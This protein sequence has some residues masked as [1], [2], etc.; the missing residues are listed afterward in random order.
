MSV[1]NRRADDP[2]QHPSVYA[3]HGKRWLLV[4]DYGV[5]AWIAV[6]KN[7]TEERVIAAH[8]EAEMISKLDAVEREQD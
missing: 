6:R 7:G 2:P 5:A 3:C 8:T 4:Y 1:E